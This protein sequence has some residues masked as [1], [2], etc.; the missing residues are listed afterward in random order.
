M[1]VINWSIGIILFL[2]FI[3]KQSNRILIMELFSPDYE[4]T[5]SNTAPGPMK[6]RSLSTQMSS[7][8]SSS[9]TSSSSS[10]DTNSTVSSSSVHD[11]NQA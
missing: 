3:C 7:G 1:D 8:S 5:S 4:D 9:S 6:I 11:P 2:L 10:C